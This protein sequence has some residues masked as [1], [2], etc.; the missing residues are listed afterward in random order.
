MALTM[1]RVT[2][3][4]HLGQD[5]KLAGEGERKPAILSLATSDTWKDRES[6]E[7][8]T[9]TEWHRV[10]IFN[11]HLVEVVSKHARK[12][13]KLFVEGELR[14]HRWTDDNQVERWTTEVV[15]GRF[16]GEVIVLER[17][18]ETGGGE[19]PPRELD[20]DIPY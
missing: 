6:G 4:G 7:R 2:L 5:P 8:K 3:I 13:S 1:N 20:G 11:P 14:T 16:G 10:A 17:A 18:T 19:T 15:I 9:R 12:G